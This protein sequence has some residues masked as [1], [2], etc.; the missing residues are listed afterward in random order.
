M[1][2]ESKGR[3]GVDDGD[4]EEEENVNTDGFTL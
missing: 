1:R 4:G 3:P 2:W